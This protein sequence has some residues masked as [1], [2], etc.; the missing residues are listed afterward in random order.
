MRVHHRLTLSPL[1]PRP[2]DLGL[3]SLLLPEL[4]PRQ[5]AALE[6]GQNVLAHA[7]AHVDAIAAA[8]RS[9]AHGSACSSDGRGSVGS[10]ASDV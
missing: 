1:Q 6:V 5:A 10:Q 4:L 2:E 3:E 8:A 7:R 9:S